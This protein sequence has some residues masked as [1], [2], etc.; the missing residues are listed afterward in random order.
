M[1]PLNLDTVCKLY[2][3]TFSFFY[4]ANR[5]LLIFSISPLYLLLLFLLQNIPF[6]TIPTSQVSTCL[7]HI[8]LS[9]RYSD[10]LMLLLRG[11][12]SKALKLWSGCSPRPAWNNYPRWTLCLAIHTSCS[13]PNQSLTVLTVCQLLSILVVAHL[14]RNSDTVTVKAG[15]SSVARCQ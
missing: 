12:R 9:M 10:T 3:L 11:T 2:L 15:L 8:L 6:L 7:H 5:C 1:F 14:D 13:M 4:L